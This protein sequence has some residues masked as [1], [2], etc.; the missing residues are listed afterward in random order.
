MLILREVILCIHTLILFLKVKHLLH[1]VAKL[2][3]T[4]IFIF[5]YIYSLTVL[6]VGKFGVKPDDFPIG[7]AAAYAYGKTSDGNYNA[8]VIDLLGN[9]LEDLF[10]LCN[11]SFSL[12]TI[13][14]IAIQL[15]SYQSFP[16]PVHFDC[17]TLKLRK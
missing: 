6:T 12:K 14:M 3:I 1:K 9:S 15:V 11:R 16:L 10:N 2:K 4:V 5:C 13:L 8:L 17:L 7:F